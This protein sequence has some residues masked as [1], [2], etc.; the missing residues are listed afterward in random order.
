M[1]IGIA[2]TPTRAFKDDPIASRPASPAPKIEPSVHTA[3]TDP[4]ETILYRPTGPSPKIKPSVHIALTDPEDAIPYRTSAPPPT[5][6]AAIHQANIMF[7]PLCYLC[8]KYG[9]KSG[10]GFWG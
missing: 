7:A 4:E 9:S 8:G 10:R 3:P 5:A 2:S 1:I 6:S